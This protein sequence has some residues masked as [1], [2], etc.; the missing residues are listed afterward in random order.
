MARA[1]HLLTI[2]ICVVPQIAAAGGMCSRAD[3]A[4][5]ATVN[6]MLLE[7]KDLTEVDCH[8]VPEG[9]KCSM[10]CE[11]KD[12]LTDESRRGL[13][14]SLIADVAYAA[15]KRGVSHFGHIDFIDRSLTRAG[16]R[17]TMSVEQAADLQRKLKSDA[18]TEDAFDT[19]VDNG[20]QKV[21]TKPK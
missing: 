1:L 2:G 8:G 16:T 14:E 6:R 10:I 17:L 5:I 19:A 18:I 3:L 21:P 13:L 7:V 11:S 4:A 15:N 20:F 12:A 9:P